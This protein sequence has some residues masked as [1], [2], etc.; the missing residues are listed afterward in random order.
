MAITKAKLQALI[1]AGEIT[2]IGGGSGTVG[3]TFRV[4]I[5]TGLLMVTVSDDY[6]GATFYVNPETGNLEVTQE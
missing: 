2:G 5:E 4:D 3:A 1:D 6:S